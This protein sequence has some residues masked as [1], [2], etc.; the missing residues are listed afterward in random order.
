MLRRGRGGVGAATLL[1]RFNKEVPLPAGPEP[2]DPT[3]PFRLRRFTSC[4]MGLY[5]HCFKLLEHGLMQASDE[6][7][8]YYMFPSPPRMGTGRRMSK[9]GKNTN[10]NLCG[11]PGSEDVTR[12]AFQAFLTHPEQNGVHLRRTQLKIWQLVEHRAKTLGA[13]G[14]GGSVSMFRSVGTARMMVVSM[15]AFIDASADGFDEEVWV[16]AT[17]MK[18]VMY[19]MDRFSEWTITPHADST[20]YSTLVATTGDGGA[21]KR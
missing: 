14:G 13:N 5:D 1:G 2:E 8:S 15:D 21:P 10:L 16:R 9:I 12:P 11:L 19:G 20:G 4:G 17:S 7:L 18:E 3:D 6:Y